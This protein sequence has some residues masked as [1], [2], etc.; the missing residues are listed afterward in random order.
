V[1][2]AVQRGDIPAAR[3]HE[4]AQRILDAKARY[5]LLDWQPLDP[6]SAADRS[7]KEAHEALIAD[8]FQ[9]GVTVVYDHGDLLPVPPDRSVAVIFLATRNYT[10]AACGTYRDDIHWSAVALHP[11]DDEIARAV[12]AANRVDTVI[13]FTENAIDNRQQQAL[14]RA[15]PPEKTAVVALSSPYDWQQFPDVAAYVLTH[16]P[17]PP[18]VP[19]ACAVLFGAAPARGILPE[20]LSSDLPAG[21]HAD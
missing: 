13:V 9:A 18:A 11:A 14:V 19:A 10:Q 17:L 7:Q 4:S 2:D 15:L 5:G 12:D 21:S 20:T 8:L 3:I 16:S 6:A 1:I